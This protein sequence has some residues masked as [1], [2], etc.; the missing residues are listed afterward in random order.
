MAKTIDVISSGWNKGYEI[1]ES[2]DRITITIQA[3]D[4]PDNRL[5]IARSVL[6]RLAAAL[7]SIDPFPKLE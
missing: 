3:I 7:A 5:Q 2:D 6:P 4:N 1:S